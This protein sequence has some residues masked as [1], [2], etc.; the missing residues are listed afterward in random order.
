M[1]TYVN[2]AILR[3]KLI[4]LFQYVVHID[5]TAFVKFDENDTGWMEVTQSLS[6]SLS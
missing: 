2:N 3:H 4:Y 6:L 5:H 1:F